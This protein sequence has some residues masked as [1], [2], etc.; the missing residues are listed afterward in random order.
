ME[1]IKHDTKTN[2]PIKIQAEDPNRSFSKEDIQMANG[3]T[4]RHSASLVLREMHI[5]TTAMYRPTAV[6]TAIMKKSSNTSMARMW[7][8]GNPRA[9]YIGTATMGNNVEIS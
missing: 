8:K 4:R 9:L 2:N 7:R 1:L 6:R 5:K 3:H